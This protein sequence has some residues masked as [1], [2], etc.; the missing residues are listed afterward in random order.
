MLLDH[1]VVGTSLPLL[2]HEVP[3]IRRRYF[4]A[5]KLDGPRSI[6]A[7]EDSMLV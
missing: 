5:A 4:G 7:C 2:A 6:R 3:P 1:P